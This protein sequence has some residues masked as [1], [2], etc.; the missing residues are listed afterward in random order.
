MKQLEPQDRTG[1]AATG[2]EP[3]YHQIPV[4]K[5]HVRDHMAAAAIPLGSIV[6]ILL[7]L[8]TV[9]CLGLALGILIR[10]LWMA[11]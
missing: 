11:A 9:A 5:I 2:R 6:V 3:G 1:P 8:A 4:R 10:V 7:W